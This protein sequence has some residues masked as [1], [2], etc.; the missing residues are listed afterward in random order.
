MKKKEK[1][2]FAASSCFPFFSATSTNFTCRSI[3]YLACACFITSVL[4]MLSFA[5]CL[6]FQNAPSSRSTAPSILLF[7]LLSLVEQK[8]TL[9]NNFDNG[10]SAQSFFLLYAKTN[11]SE[12]KKMCFAP[13]SRVSQFYFDCINTTEMKVNN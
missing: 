10:P 11:K 8:S 4:F 5:P 1:R 3:N 7:I 6:N 12:Q 13:S 2:N 9:T